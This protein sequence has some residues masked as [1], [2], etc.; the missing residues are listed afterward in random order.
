MLNLLTTIT[1]FTSYYPVRRALEKGDWLTAGIISFAGISSAVSHLFES[2]KHL[3]DGFGTDPK[4]SYLL[5]RVDVFAVVVTLGRVL[6]LWS[7]GNFRIFEHRNLLS[8][9][10]LAW[11]CNLISEQDPGYTYYLPFHCIWHLSIFL[12]LDR[13]L[14]SVY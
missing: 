9:L 10:I 8:K 4:I 12:I 14:E 7:R 13:Y 5:N 11:G 3:M 1:N 2:H 6:Y